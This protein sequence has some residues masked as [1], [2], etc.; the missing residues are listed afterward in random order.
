MSAFYLVSYA[1]VQ[2]LTGSRSWILF[3]VRH[4]R[5]VVGV[6]RSQVRQHEVRVGLR[7]HVT[8]IRE[9]PALV[10]SGVMTLFLLEAN[11]KTLDRCR[12]GAFGGVGDVG[13]DCEV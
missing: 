5:R 3:L 13:C 2:A 10:G 4:F 12:S 7:A 1:Q 8:V 9:L 6:L 11:E